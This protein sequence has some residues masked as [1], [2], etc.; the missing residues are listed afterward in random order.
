MVSGSNSY[1]N[2]KSND[3]LYHRMGGLQCTMCQPVYNY[4]W[5]TVDFGT[6]YYVG[7]VFIV[8]RK[9]CCQERM[10]NLV[11]RIGN[12]SSNGEDSNPQCGERFSMTHLPSF[13]AYCDPYGVGRYLSIR[14]YDSVDM[15]LCEVAVFRVENGKT[16]MFHCFHQS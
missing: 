8:G 3:G 7:E 6:V 1:E 12:S 11:V 10:R 4:V 14:K 15:A 9:D 13:S 16:T 2:L 5:W